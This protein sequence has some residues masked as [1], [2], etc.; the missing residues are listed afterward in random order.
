MI[1]NGDW[2]LDGYAAAKDDATAASATTW[3]SVRCRRSTGYEDPHPY[4]AGT[5]LMASK[6]VGDDPDLKTVVVGD[7]MKFATAKEQQI[8]LVKTLRRLPGNAEAIADLDRDQRHP[9]RP[10]PRR[11][12]SCGVPQP[13]NL[14][15]RC[16]FDS[17]TAGVRDLFTGNADVAGIAATMQTSTG[18]LHLPAVALETTRDA[19][20]PGVDDHSRRASARHRAGGRR[21]R[22]PRGGPT[23]SGRSGR[24]CS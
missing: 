14:E 4:I 10:V 3:A 18:D 24:R 16:V 21:S 22:E 5:F 20:R 23:A 8:D 17:M 1:V 19:P 13:T 15:M 7:F 2:T 6:A 12:P 11:P 9:A